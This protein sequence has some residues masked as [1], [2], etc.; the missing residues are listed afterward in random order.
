METTSTLATLGAINT[1][2]QNIALALRVQPFWNTQWFAAV[3]GA[4]I[5]LTPSFYLLYKDRPIIKV[6]AGPAL[7][8]TSGNQVEKALWVK[9]SNT[10][11][12]SITVSSTFLK[13]KNGETMVFFDDGL[14]IGGS[15]LP[16]VINEASSHTVNVSIPGIEADIRKRKDYP[17]AACYRDAL[18]KE[19]EAKLSRE[20]WE[21]LF[22]VKI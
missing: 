5:G 3:V 1:S 20:L 13:F 22:T 15:G 14:F 21:K 10:G 4:A 11:R 9:I 7:F 17:V 18:G 12:R 6:G 16:K 8:R 19:Y 2:L